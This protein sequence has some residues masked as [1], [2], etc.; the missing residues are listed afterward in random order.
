VADLE[1][2]VTQNEDG[3]YEVDEGASP[4][5]RNLGRA[6]CRYFEKRCE[7]APSIR[8]CPADILALEGTTTEFFEE[9]VG[10][11]R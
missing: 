2:L 11:G 4:V 5:S 10:S 7:D 6:L 1:Q 3:L 9:M 8:D